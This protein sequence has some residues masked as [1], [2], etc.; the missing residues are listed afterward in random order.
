MFGYILLNRFSKTFTL[1]NFFFFS[2]FSM[3]N[4]VYKKK[5]M[6]GLRFSVDHSMTSSTGVKRNCVPFYDSI[7]LP[8]QSDFWNKVP[9]NFKTKYFHWSLLYIFRCEC[10]SEP[11]LR[12]VVKTLLGRQWP[13]KYDSQIQILNCHLLKPKL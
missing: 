9:V 10:R 7:F 3:Y 13:L 2:Y 8:S 1:I 11:T 4:T 5:Y 12:I 6:A